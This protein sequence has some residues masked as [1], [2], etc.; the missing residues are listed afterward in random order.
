MEKLSLKGLKFETTEIIIKD[1]IM[2]ITLARPEK[3]ECNEQCH[4]E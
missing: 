1:N 2:T 3:K 4:D